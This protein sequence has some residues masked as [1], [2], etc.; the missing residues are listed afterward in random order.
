MPWSIFVFWMFFFGLIGILAAGWFT[1]AD[2]W[3]WFVGGILLIF[4]LSATIK[5]IVDRR[6][7][8][9]RFISMLGSWM[10]LLI[11]I[12]LFYIIGILAAG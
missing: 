11:V 5:F 3:I 7:R 9:P 8:R 10:F 1:I 4:A 6:G 2:W 12:L